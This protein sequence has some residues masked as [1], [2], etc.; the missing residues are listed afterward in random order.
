[1]ADALLLTLT[2]NPSVDHSVT[3]ERWCK[4]RTNRPLDFWRDP[5]GKGINV[6][7]VIHRL[8][9]QTLALGLVGGPTG[10]L[11]REA[12]VREGVPCDL[13]PVSGDTRLNTIIT[14]LTDETQTR[15]NL[16]GPE[17]SADELEA[18]Y[19]RLDAIPNPAFLI[20]GGSLP[21]G[22]PD[23]IYENLV[24][25]FRARGVRTL[26]DADGEPLRRGVAARPF[27]IKPN[28]YEVAELVGE[29]PRNLEEYIEAATRLAGQAAEIVV[30]SLGEQ[31]AVAATGQHVLRARAPHV[32]PMSAVG[33][34]DSMVG[35]MAL[36]L[37]RGELLED[38]LRWG[39]AAGAAAV[40]TP[41]TELCRPEDVHRLL[42]EVRVEQVG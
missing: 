36:S 40:I 39:T 11:V 28:E 1:M 14:D 30:L 17:V 42:K 12:L 35:A 25:A 10:E 18:L 22:V 3:V 29:R 24:N 2:L 33:A 41:G 31:G 16:P 34:G 38:A 27:L 32:E 23:A 21:R 26:L 19:Q 4:G 37:S 6:S 20:L 8:G 7:R 9:G 5:G 13:T 15:L